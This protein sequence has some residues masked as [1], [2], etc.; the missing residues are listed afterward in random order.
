MN[1][2]WRLTAALGLG[3]LVLGA[4]YLFSSPAATTPMTKL[5]DRVLPDLIAE[6]VTKI[7][8]ARKDG[9]PLTFEKATDAVGEYWRIVEQAGHAAEPA[10]VQQLLFGLDRY[11]STGGLEPGRPETAPELTGLA[12]PRLTVAYSAGPGRREVL[13]FGKQPP[14]NTTVV[15]YQHEGDPKIYLVG[16]ETYDAFAKPALQYRA[17]NL[18]RFA[19]HRIN[20]IE[21]SYKFIRPQGKDKPEIVEYETSVLERYEEGAERGWYLVSPHK[22]RLY[23]HSVAQLITRLA[24]LQATDYQPAENLDEK[25]LTGP[26]VKVGVYAAGEDKPVVVFFGA[27]AERG[28]KRWVWSPGSAE[29]ALY[30][31]NYYDELPLQRSMLR[32]RVIFPFSS[33]NVKHLEIEVK[34]LGSVVLDRKEVRKEGDPVS[35]W[36]WEVTK[37]DNLKVESERLEAFVGHVVGQEITG[38]LGAQ[39][40]KQAGLDPAPV[41]LTVVTKEGKEHVCG[42]SAS[43]AHGFLRKEGVNEIFEVQPQLVRM[44]KRLELNFVSMEMFNVPRD[45]IHS[46]SFDSRSADL[47]P[48]Y[49]KLRRDGEKW[50]FVD[51]A[52]K[53]AAPNLDKLEGLLTQLNYIKAEALLGRDSKTIE[54][55]LLDERTA[56]AT[57]KMGYTIGT[58]AQAKEGEM[59]LY[60]SVDKSSRA[61]ET[62]YYARLKDNLAVFQINSG[63][64]LSLQKFLK[65]E[66]KPEQEK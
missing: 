51:P 2:N 20:K 45:S 40:F 36:K 3:V 37:P 49:Y 52:N 10:M 42:F 50:S 16:V 62:I 34:D 22:E 32:V 15:F 4:I 25:G 21:L 17:K 28:R 23:D 54:D 27:P 5:S 24:D 38:F 19:P 29:V 14:T 13:R 53:G 55:N 8:V 11:V 39:E 43:D 33:E 1:K 63:I 12:D 31:S 44:L 61:T 30:D 35:T 57:L 26:Q 9:G 56:P 59:E 48:V 41:K 65:A 7:E 66:D 58:G 18:V 46:I 6:R 64:V 47:K 60:I